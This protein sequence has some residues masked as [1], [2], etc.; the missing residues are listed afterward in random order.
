MKLKT[1]ACL[2]AGALMSVTQAMAAPLVT[3][4]LSVDINGANYGGGQTVGPTLAGFEGW[5]AFEGFDQLDPNYN[6]AEDWGNTGGPPNG[7]TKSFAS[8]EGNITANLIGVPT[9]QS[10]RGARNRGANTGGFPELYQDFPFAQRNGADAA[11]GR[12]FIKLVL[13]GLTPNQAYEFTGFAREAAFNAAALENPDDPG[14]SYQA[15]TDLAALGG[16]DGPAAWLDA[17]VGAGASYN[18]IWV[19]VDDD[20]DPNTPA[21]N[22]NTGYKNPIPT[23]ARS[24][25]AGPD[26]LSTGNPYF[27]SASFLTRADGSGAIT[28]Y[29]WSDPNGFGGTVQGASLL[30]G[31]QLGIIPEPATLL[32]FGLGMTFVVAMRRSAR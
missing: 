21:V 11:H 7:L 30:N 18:P 6:P 3:P 17:N 22:T 14:Q 26:S 32:M 12:N 2:V 10:N 24:Q 31:F 5:N 23:L 8:S 15:W 28:V 4:F 29:T 27:H 16:V 25:V 9:A 1:Y 13:S 20:M 19:P